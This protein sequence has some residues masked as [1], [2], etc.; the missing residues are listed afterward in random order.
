MK[1]RIKKVVKNED[2]NWKPNKIKSNSQE[3]NQKNNNEKNNKKITIKRMRIRL[4]KKNHMKL[5]D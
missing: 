5:N 1:K 3:Q 4:D 2:Q